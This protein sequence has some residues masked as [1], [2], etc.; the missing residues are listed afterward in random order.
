MRWRVD[1]WESGS[2]KP[3]IFCLFFWEMERGAVV[4]DGTQRFDPRSRWRKAV[5][6]RLCMKCWWGERGGDVAETRVGVLLFLRVFPVSLLYPTTT[7][8]SPHTHVPPA[9]FLLPCAVSSLQVL[10]QVLL[11]PLEP[12]QPSNQPTNHSVMR[13]STWSLFLYHNCSYIF[14]TW[15]HLPACPP[16]SVA[17][18]RSVTY[19]W[20]KHGHGRRMVLSPPPRLLSSSITQTSEMLTYSA[21]LML[22]RGL[23]N[24]ERWQGYER[25]RSQRTHKRKKSPAYYQNPCRCTYVLPKREWER[26]RLL[27]SAYMAHYTTQFSPDVRSGRSLLTRL[28]IGKQFGRIYKIT[29]HFPHQ[30][31]FPLSSN[32]QFF[33]TERQRQAGGEAIYQS[34]VCGM[35][36]VKTSL[37]S[38]NIQRPRLSSLVLCV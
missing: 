36:Y 16:F 1:L 5:L 35:E 10:L 21:V 19:I 13:N 11:P 3:Y 9:A 18:S 17:T 23:W 12:H 6:L 27:I 15:T 37:P 28:E 22:Y 20:P 30:L 14:C 8:S 25:T 7:T 26:R 2:D 33:P 34:V 38:N 24:I 4:G 31:H 32:E 29:H